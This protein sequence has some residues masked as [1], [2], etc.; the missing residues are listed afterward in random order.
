MSLKR[1]SDAAGHYTLLNVTVNTDA[2]VGISS[3]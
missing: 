2:D 3:L 1:K